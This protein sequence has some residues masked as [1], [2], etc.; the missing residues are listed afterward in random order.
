M[1]NT[2][3]IQKIGYCDVQYAYN[4][5]ARYIIINTLSSH[6]QDYLIKN[7]ITIVQEEEMINS[8]LKENK[9]I[10]I[11]IY[12]KNA[13]DET[14]IKK[15]QQLYALGFTNIYIYVGGLFEWTLLQDL[16]DFENFPTTTKLSDS[17]RFQP[18]NKLNI[19]LIS[20]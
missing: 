3:T 16:Y 10:N 13:T 12:G 17:L 9:D 19:Q 6:E 14:V 11:I 1:G 20:Y 5:P 8:K 2:L 15:S 4:N 7:T 18:S